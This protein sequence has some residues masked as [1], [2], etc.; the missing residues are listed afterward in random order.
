MERARKTNQRE[1]DK[2]V[3]REPLFLAALLANAIPRTSNNMLE[4]AR[5]QIVI[6]TAIESEP[7]CSSALAHALLLARKTAALSAQPGLGRNTIP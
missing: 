1:L 4:L 6:Q 3:A 5:L 7:S 2:Q